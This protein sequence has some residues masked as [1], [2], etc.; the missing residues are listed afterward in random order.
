MSIQQMRELACTLQNNLNA[1]DAGISMSR[2]VAYDNNRGNGYSYGHGNAN[3]NG[4]GSNGHGS[5][6]YGTTDR[7]VEVYGERRDRAD[8]FKR[9]RSRSRSPVK[10]S[11]SI[12]PPRYMRES[13]TTGSARNGLSVEGLRSQKSRAWG[14]VFNMMD[15]IKHITCS[16]DVKLQKM[17]QRAQDSDREDE[18]EEEGQHPESVSGLMKNFI[19]DI[20]E[21]TKCSLT[22]RAIQHDESLVWVG[23]CKHVAHIGCGIDFRNEEMPACKKCGEKFNVPRARVAMNLEHRFSA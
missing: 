12:T 10:R 3:G 16:Y 1:Y 17:L 9:S 11:R 20:S 7:R 6:Y 4:N 13:N 14:V 15:D 23:N 5:S 8:R 22:K 2:H 18:D 21:L 19:D